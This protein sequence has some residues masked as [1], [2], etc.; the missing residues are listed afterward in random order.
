MLRQT[1]S[2]QNEKTKDDVWSKA[3]KKAEEDNQHS[4]EEDFVDHVNRRIKESS[5]EVSRD[6]VP[7][8]IDKKRDEIYF[9]QEKVQRMGR[10]N[11]SVWFLTDSDETLVLQVLSE[12][13]NSY[14]LNLG[15]VSSQ[16]KGDVTRYDIKI[17]FI[18][19]EERQKNI[20]EETVENAREMREYKDI[21]EDDIVGDCPNDG[22]DGKKYRNGM[23]SCGPKYECNRFGCGFKFVRDVL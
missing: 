18:S 21:D 23:G 16:T 15:I 7:V 6:Y 1:Y 2:R 22:C 9:S 17:P 3:E 12:I 8:E 20:R 4:T 14:N 13:L 5:I 19:E 10:T 11:D